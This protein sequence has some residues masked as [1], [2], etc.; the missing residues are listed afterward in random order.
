MIRCGILQ[1]VI[2]L[3]Y[4]LLRCVLLMEILLLG[5]IATEK[6]LPHTQCDGEFLIGKL[7][8]SAMASLNAAL[9]RSNPYMFR[10]NAVSHREA[11]KEN[12]RVC[13]NMNKFAF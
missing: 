10:G 11:Y 8:R 9:C 6:V 12:C 5:M 7:Y 3:L 4:P 2:Q 1:I 13:L